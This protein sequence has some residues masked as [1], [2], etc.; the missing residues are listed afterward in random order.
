MTNTVTVPNRIPAKASISSHTGRSTERVVLPMPPEMTDLGAGLDTRFEMEI[1]ARFMRHLR[2]VP[3]SRMDIKILSSIQFTADMLD[4][5]AEMVAKTLVDQG[6][7][8]PRTAFPGAY[9]DF[10][11][12]CALRR[13]WGATGTDP[14]GPPH[15]VMALRDFWN[16]IGEDRFGPFPVQY[17]IFNQ[18]NLVSR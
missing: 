4:I 6:L 15:S 1:Y 8:A 5:S 18:T 13:S 11:D 7:R 3:N 10:C 9:L 12:R 16:G 14:G 17:A 2:N